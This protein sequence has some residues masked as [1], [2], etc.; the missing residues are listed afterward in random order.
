MEVN[1][2]KKY[3]QWINHTHPQFVLMLQCSDDVVNSVYLK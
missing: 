1:R 2:D 3:N